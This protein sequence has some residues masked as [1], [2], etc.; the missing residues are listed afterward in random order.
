MEDPHPE[1]QPGY[2]D[3]SN[4]GPRAFFGGF[5]F[6]FFTALLMFAILL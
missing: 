5:L 1:L 2:G 3:L 6:G 4:E